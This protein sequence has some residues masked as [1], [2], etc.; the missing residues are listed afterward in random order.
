M[1]G[2]MLTTVAILLF[3]MSGFHSIVGERLILQPINK[4][5][6]LPKIWGSR[7]ATFRTIE[8]SWHLVSIL[9]VGL[10]IHLLTI[11][12]YPQYTPKSFLII[13]GV[14]FGILAIVPLVWNAGKHKSWLVFGLICA[15]YDGDITLPSFS[16]L[17]WVVIVGLGGL[18]AHFCITTALQLAPATVV[19][20]VDFTRLPLIAIIGMVFYNEVLDIWVIIGAIIIFG[21]NYLNIWAETRKKEIE[22]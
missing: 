4:A 6:N 9:W 10:A 13:F 14:I 8:A 15:G 5:D 18:F 21:S 11:Q 20:P 17:P 3:L 16:T 2:P 7:Q 22:V 19:M 12:F 1:R